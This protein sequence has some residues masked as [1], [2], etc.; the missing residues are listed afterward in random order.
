MDNLFY[1]MAPRPSKISNIKTNKTQPISVK[2]QVLFV[3]PELQLKLQLQL[4]VNHFILFL[5]TFFL[6]SVTHEKIKTIRIFL[7]L[8]VKSIQFEFS[9]H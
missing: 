5:L 2:T 3:K 8:K 6:K 1:Y 4:L 7:T 9:Q